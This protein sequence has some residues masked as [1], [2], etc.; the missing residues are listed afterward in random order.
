MKYVCYVKDNTELHADV[1]SHFMSCFML[2][3]MDGYIGVNCSTPCPVSYYGH[4]CN[5][6]C[7]C[8]IEYCHHEHGCRVTQSKILVCLFALFEFFFA[9]KFITHCFKILRF[10]IKF[11]DV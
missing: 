11:M 6:K 4:D 2:A 5:S 1:M 3:C 8:S 10:A 9:N 7:D